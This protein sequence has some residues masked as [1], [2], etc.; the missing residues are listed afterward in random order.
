MTRNLCW[1]EY[2]WQGIRYIQILSHLRM[3]KSDLD[4]DQLRLYGFETVCHWRVINLHRFGIHRH[5]RVAILKYLYVQGSLQF[6]ELISRFNELH[7]DHEDDANGI[8]SS[9]Q[10]CFREKVTVES[11]NGSLHDK[12]RLRWIGG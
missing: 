6:G 3:W 1:K 8:A 2:P 10:S 5:A 4:R 12:R 11:P 9:R 7:A